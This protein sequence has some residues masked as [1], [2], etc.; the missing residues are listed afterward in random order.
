MTDYNKIKPADT[1]V[2]KEYYYLEINIPSLKVLDISVFATV[3]EREAYELDMTDHYNI[4]YNGRVMEKGPPGVNRGNCVS[5]FIGKW[6]FIREPASNVAA[7]SKENDQ[8]TALELLQEVGKA[9]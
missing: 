7:G 3:E 1:E 8:E 9:E 4:K 6:R 5:S 2:G